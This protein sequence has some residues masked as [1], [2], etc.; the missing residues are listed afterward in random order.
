MVPPL[1]FWCKLAF[2]S[3]KKFTGVDAY[4]LISYLPPETAQVC[5]AS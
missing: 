4:F 3:Q 1:T 5:R 2:K